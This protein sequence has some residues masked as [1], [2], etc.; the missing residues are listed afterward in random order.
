MFPERRPPNPA[1]SRCFPNFSVSVFQLFSV[2][3][4]EPIRHLRKPRNRSILRNFPA[5]QRRKMNP[6]QLFLQDPNES[7]KIQANSG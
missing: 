2:L 1:R 3:R 4:N 7:A 6:F 5:S